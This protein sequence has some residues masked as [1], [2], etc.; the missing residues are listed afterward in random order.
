MKEAQQAGL[1]PILEVSAE[2]MRAVIVASGTTVGYGGTFVAPQPLKLITLNCG[3]ADGFPRALANRAYVGFQ[4]SSYPVVGR[5]S[6]DTLTV[7]VPLSVAI[8]PGDRMTLL[9]RNPGD[10]NSVA[11]TARLLHTIPYEVTCA[12]NRRVLRHPI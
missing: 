2:V 5:I 3:F 4:G 12:L 10:R 9:S 6:M 7:A 8:R 11:N 1:K